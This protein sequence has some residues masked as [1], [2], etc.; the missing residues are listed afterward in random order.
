[1]KLDGFPDYV[2]DYHE[3]VAKQYDYSQ[4]GNRV[5]WEAVKHRL[6][7]V[8]GQVVAQ[9][10]SFEADRLFKFECEATE[11]QLVTQADDGSYIL[12]AVLTSTNP[13]VNGRYFTEEDLKTL[14]ERINEN[15]LT[16][17]DIE[18]H[19][20][21]MNVAV[22]QAFDSD[23]IRETLSQMRGKLEDVKAS[24]KEGKLW[25][26]AKLDETYKNVAESF[27]GLSLEA[28]ANPTDDGRMKDPD[29]VGFIFT[30]EPKNPD[31]SIAS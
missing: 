27:S 7:S 14:A 5:A 15:G 28:L 17:P 6:N 18:D 13:D 31:A 25:L 10:E 4:V 29:P 21:F 1:M 11:Q 20:Q 24:V 19:E 26:Q 22:S 9:R 12:D 30:D 23:S 2:Q 8:D 16:A 3:H